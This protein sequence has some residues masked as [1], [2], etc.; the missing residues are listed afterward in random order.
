MR[1]RAHGPTL[2]V[3]K[4]LPCRRGQLG[5]LLCAE[6]SPGSPGSASLLETPNKPLASELCYFSAGLKCSLL[7]A[8]KS[9]L[10]HL[11]ACRHTPNVAPDPQ[12]AP[13]EPASWGRGGSGWL[14][15][16]K[17]EFTAW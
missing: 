6:G 5:V 10:D 15:V 11:A 14:S 16:C 4:G 1:G 8:A 17:G 2:D 13:A 3:P 7:Q 9:N 12:L